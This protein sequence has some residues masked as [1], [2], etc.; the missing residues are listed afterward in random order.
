VSTRA[1]VAVAAVV[2]LLSAIG[3]GIIVSRWVSDDEHVSTPPRGLTE[4]PAVA[5]FAGYREVRV[6]IDH[7]CARVVVADTDARREQG[8]RGASDLGPYAGMLFVQPGA[9]DIPFTMAGVRDPLDIEW[10]ASDGSRV[11][12]AH[13]RPCPERG[14]DCPLYRSPRPYRTALETP[15]G[16]ASRVSVSPCV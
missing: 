4:T 5:P 12:A 6:E 7:R 13:M 16:T 2:A 11:G 14:A 10:F 8:L 9:S 1:P 15:A 3:I